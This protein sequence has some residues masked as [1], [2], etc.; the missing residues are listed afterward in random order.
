[1][2]NF[3]SRPNILTCLNMYNSVALEELNAM[4]TLLSSRIASLEGTLGYKP[5]QATYIQHLAAR[6]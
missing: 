1:M 3:D 4:V 2:S 6:L 5:L